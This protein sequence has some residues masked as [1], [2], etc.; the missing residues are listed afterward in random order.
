MRGKVAEY[1]CS[2]GE[3]ARD[4]AHRHETDP[5]IPANYDPMCRSCHKA[6]DLLGWLKEERQLE[7]D[8]I[9]SGRSFKGWSPERREAQRQRMLEKWGSPEERAKQAERAKRDQ[10]WRG[11]RPRGGDAR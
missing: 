10:P 9:E 11:R 3:Q 1:L 4:W 2:C 8:R 6:Y 7:R 5:A